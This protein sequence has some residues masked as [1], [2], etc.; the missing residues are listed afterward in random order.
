MNPTATPV[1]QELA[2]NAQPVEPSAREISCTT[3]KALTMSSP[4]PP[5]SSGTRIQNKPAS[6]SAW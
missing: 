5:Y 3:L 1:L 2:M 4:A 6:A